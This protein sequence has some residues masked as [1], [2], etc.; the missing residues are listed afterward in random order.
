MAKI[1]TIHQNE[2]SNVVSKASCIGSGGRKADVSSSIQAVIL[3]VIADVLVTGA[4]LKRAIYIIAKKYI[5]RIQQE[6]LEAIFFI[7]FRF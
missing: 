5:S 7:R 1:V 4:E 6:L 2:V 3:V